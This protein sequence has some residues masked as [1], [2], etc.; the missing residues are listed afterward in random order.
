MTQLIH[1]VTD[2]LRFGPVNMFLFLRYLFFFGGG[3]SIRA[4][5]PDPLVAWAMTHNVY[6]MTHHDTAKMFVACCITNDSMGKN[7][8]RKQN[9]PG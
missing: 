9:V 1:R 3:E 4:K 8:H 2:R 7:G 5:S 6:A